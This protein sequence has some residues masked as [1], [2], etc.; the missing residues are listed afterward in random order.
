[1]ILSIPITEAVVLSACVA[2][3]YT[4]IG[5]LYAVAY[6]DVIQLCSIMV[7]LVRENF[8]EPFASPCVGQRAACVR[9]ACCLCHSLCD[10]K[11]PPQS[12]DGHTLCTLHRVYHQTLL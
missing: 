8:K 11:L 9:P 1:M 4:L 6:T 12:S 7:G 3:F 2:V 10:P 5:G